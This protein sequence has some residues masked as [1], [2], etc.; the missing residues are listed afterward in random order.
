[1]LYKWIFFIHLTIKFYDRINCNFPVQKQNMQHLLILVQRFIIMALPKLFSTKNA[2]NKK[3]SP[4]FLL[5]TI[6]NYDTAA[7]FGTK[8]RNSSGYK[9]VVRAA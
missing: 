3:K 5:I 8:R 6:T 2:E 1:M 7:V 9:R 4:P